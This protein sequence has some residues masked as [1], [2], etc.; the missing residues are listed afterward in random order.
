MPEQPQVNELQPFCNVRPGPV[1]FGVGEASATVVNEDGEQG[2][3][4]MVMLRLEHLAG[5]T[6]VMLEPERAAMLAQALV[7]AANSVAVKAGPKLV[8]P[9]VATIQDLHR[10]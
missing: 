10:R 6:I 3:V 1:A 2:Q 8:V 7:Q 9:D 5:G 4:L